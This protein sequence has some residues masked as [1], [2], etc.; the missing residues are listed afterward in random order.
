MCLTSSPEASKVRS[1]QLEGHQGS[2]SCQRPIQLDQHW[3]LIEPDRE[4]GLVGNDDDLST[5]RFV[6]EMYT[7]IGNAE[8]NVMV[9]GFTACLGTVVRY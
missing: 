9:L 7:N 5:S 3:V 4:F 2:E 1:N 6:A 8:S